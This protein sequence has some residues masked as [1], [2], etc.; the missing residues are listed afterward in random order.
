MQGDGR[1]WTSSQGQDMKQENVT[2]RDPELSQIKSHRNMAQYR[3]GGE[4]V[5]VVFDPSF[6]A[7]QPLT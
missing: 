6:H 1:R 4:S 2:Q 7:S 5:L 3:D